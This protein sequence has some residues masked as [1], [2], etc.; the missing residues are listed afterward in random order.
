MKTRYQKNK[1]KFCEEVV[2]DEN[3]E[4]SISD[5]DTEYEPTNDEC[6]DSDTL[7]EKSMDVSENIVKNSKG[8]IQSVDSMSKKDKMI[9]V[10]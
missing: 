4:S 9:C 6:S 3:T 1:R 8:E 7:S 5:T 10:A 2:E